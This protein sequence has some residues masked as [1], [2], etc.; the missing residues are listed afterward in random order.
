M[1]PNSIVRYRNAP[2]IEGVIDIRVKYSDP[3]SLMK[4]LECFADRLADKFPRQEPIEQLTMAA[5]AKGGRFSSPEPPDCRQVGIKL[6]GSTNDRILMVGE[7]GFTYSHLPPY[8]NWD[9]FQNE[10]HGIWNQF[11]SECPLVGIKRLAVRYI[12]RLHLPIGDIDLADYLILRPQVP[13]SI[14]RISG[15]MMQVHVPQPDITGKSL[16]FVT[17]ASEEARD[18]GSQPLILDLDVFTE[19]ALGSADDIWSI[20]EALREKKNFLFESCLTEKMKGQFR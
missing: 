9:N 6:F 8:T 7:N 5:K 3:L 1:P 12:N 15:L 2:I 4:Q 10:A 13:E 18:P 11:V 20:L 19:C 16:A 14:G 17:L